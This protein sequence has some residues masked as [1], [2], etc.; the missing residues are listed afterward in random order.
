MA[1]PQLRWEVAKPAPQEYLARFRDL[2]PSIAQCLYNRG[3]KSPQEAYAFLSGEPALARGRPGPE[4]DDP[5]QLRGIHQA[6]AHIRQA[7]RQKQRIAVYG[8]FDADGI[9]ATALLAQTISSLGGQAWPYI[10]HRVDEGYGLHREALERLAEKGCRLLVTV[11]CGVRSIEEVRY[12]QQLGLEVIVTDHHSPPS[13]LPPALAVV[14]PKREDC[15]YPFKGLS[16]AGVAFKLAQALL[17]VERRVPLSRKSTPLEEEELLDLV[18][19]GTITDLSPLL[20]ENRSLVKRGLSTLNHS[21]RPG[22]LALSASLKEGTITSQTIGYILGPRLNAAGRLGD[23]MASYRLLTTSSPAEAQELALELEERNRQRKDLTLQVLEKAQKQIEGQESEPILFAQGEGFPCG[24]IG[25]VASRLSEEFYRPAVVIELGE[26]ESRGSARSIP[27]FDITKALDE[28]RDLLLRYGGHSLAAGFTVKS[29]DLATLEERLRGIAA[30][31]LSDL[32]LVPTLSIDAEVP[33]T[34]LEPAIFAAAQTLEPFGSSN[35]PP[36]F[37]SRGVEV[38]EAR[39]V[40]ETHLRFALTDPTGSC[41]D[42]DG[43]VIWDGIAFGRGEEANSLPRYIDV[44][45]V[46]EIQWWNNVERL[47]LRVLDLRPVNEV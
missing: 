37:L 9:A 1:A 15:P 28:C 23:A 47:Q 4:K 34:D 24:V 35:P 38:R 25:L 32:E 6:V 3:F 7:I 13:E 22:I 8:D 26:E 2:P 29:E 30:R 43:R 41:K 46:P 17:K 21:P 44:V 19:L 45:Y 16:G 31:Q 14:N 10:P 39:L 36:T 42:K 33:L 11:D 12:A 40:G 27:E 20:G 5:F 18:A